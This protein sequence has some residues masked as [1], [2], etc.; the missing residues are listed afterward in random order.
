MMPGAHRVYADAGFRVIESRRL[1]EARNTEFRRAV[2]GLA[3]DSFDAGARGS[4]DDDAGTLFQHQGDLVF[5]AQKYA[6][7]IN[8]DDPLPFFLTDVRRGRERLFD[9]GVVEGE[10]QSPEGLDRLLKCGLYLL[11]RATLHGRRS[12]VSLP[13]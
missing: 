9:A 3:C 12:P 7:K 11:G 2:S 13:F 6:A 10:I 8:V 1:G 5:H 4:V